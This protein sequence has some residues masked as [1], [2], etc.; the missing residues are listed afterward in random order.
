[1][2]GL[3]DADYYLKANPDIA[4]LN[5]DPLMHYLE[6]GAQEGR[7]PRPDFDVAYY[8]AQCRLLGDEP[9]N[10]LLHFITTGARQGIKT[11]PAD[12][13]LEPVDAN[14][15]TPVPIEPG[16]LEIA[17]EPTDAVV[18]P[19][20]DPTRSGRSPMQLYI[21]SAGVDEA[22]ILH[23]VGWAVCLAPIA[24]VQVFIDDERARRRGITASLARMLPRSTQT[25]PM[26]CILVSRCAPTSVR[27]AA[28]TGS[29]RFRP[30]HR[31]VFPAR[32]DSR[33]NSR[34]N[35]VRRYRT[36]MTARCR[37]SAT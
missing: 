3:F 7:G 15:Q 14:T 28:A 36:A 33:S 29:S 34:A 13:S 2:S 4:A 20:A 10:P 22:G 9:S 37:F 17:G 26:R 8:L 23:I 16:G 30:S 1:M 32:K 27:T 18:A 5:I 21:D 11:R 25:T 24:S 35:T 6:R 31:R 12:E 19:A